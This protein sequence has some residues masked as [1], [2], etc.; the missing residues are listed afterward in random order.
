MKYV[1]YRSDSDSDWGRQKRQQQLLR[2]LAAEALRPRNLPR[3]PGLLGN[4][5]EMVKTDLS[6]A[7]LLRLGLAASRLDA[8][9][10]RGDSVDGGIDLWLEDYYF[11]PDFGKMREKLYRVILGADPPDDFMAQARRDAAAYQAATSSAKATFEA[12]SRR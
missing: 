4:L 9:D 2:A 3:L 6:T 10:V 8:A 1:R 12:R 5:S 11:V 7:K